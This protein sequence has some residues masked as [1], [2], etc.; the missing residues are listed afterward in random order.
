MERFVIKWWKP[1]TI[2]TKRSILVVTAVLDPPLLTPDVAKYAKV[3]EADLIKNV[4]I[5]NSVLENTN[6]VE[7]LD[8]FVK[9]ILEN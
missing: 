6:H 5:K 3:K 2:L 9:D 7:T 4:L 8:G 1:L